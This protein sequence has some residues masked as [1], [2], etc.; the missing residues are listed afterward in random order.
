MF[1]FMFFYVCPLIKNT[2]MNLTLDPNYLFCS[3]IFKSNFKRPVV[4]FMFEGFHYALC[5]T[6]SVNLKGKW[7]DHSQLSWLRHGKTV[8]KGD[9][10]HEVFCVEVTLRKCIFFQKVYQCPLSL[11]EAKDCVPSLQLK[12]RIKTPALMACYFKVH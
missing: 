2:F 4:C 5:Q 12:H 7:K 11:S 3:H 10:H 8:T 1:L 9:R 6:D